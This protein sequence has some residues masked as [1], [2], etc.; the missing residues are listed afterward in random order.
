MKKIVCIHGSPRPDGN[1]STLANAFCSA[2]TRA[3]ATV[4]THRLYDLNYRGCVNLFHCKTGSDQCGQRD[5]L[6]TVLKHIE[7]ADVVVLASPVYFT[8]VTGPMKSCIDRWFS[9][10]VPQY[11]TAERKSRLPGGKK[12]VFIQTQGEGADRYRDLLEKYDHS[13]SLLGFQDSVLIRA[14]GVREPEDLD[15]HEGLIRQ[16]RELGRQLAT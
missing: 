13:F 5:D 6:T 14:A 9:F 3:G 16:S 4:N 2:A 10:F 11:V 8:D 1:S 15:A 12:L 7:Q